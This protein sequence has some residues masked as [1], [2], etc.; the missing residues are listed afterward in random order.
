MAGLAYAG[1]MGPEENYAELAV[2]KELVPLLN[3]APSRVVLETH[4]DFI[5]NTRFRR[6]LYAA[7]P[8]V[9]HAPVLTLAALEGL[10]F[11]LANLPANLALKGNAGAMQFDL[12]ETA[13]A[14]RTVHQLLEKGPATARQ[15][16]E[17][18][19]RPEAETLPFLQR[20]VLVRHLQPCA[21][22]AAAGWTALGSALIENAVREKKN[23]VSLPGGRSGTLHSFEMPFAMMIEASRL[24]KDGEA[25]A[26]AVLKRLKDVGYG[27]NI[28][29]AEGSTT[30][31][32]DAQVHADLLTVYAKLRD[33]AS[34]EARFLQ[35][36]GIV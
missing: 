33:P 17:A 6:D 28:R 7:A 36:H 21:V 18:L 12:N 5:A 16:H 15:I 24:Q 30:P 8:E 34:Q 3:T 20:L 31:G 19:G 32:S 2:K 4:R 27:L 13:A 26:R 10:A 22:P 11:S 29:S 35:L 9:S 23:Q 14:V 1:N 25:A